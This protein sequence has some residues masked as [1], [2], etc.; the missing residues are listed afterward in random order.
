MADRVEE[1]TNCDRWCF[2]V[3]RLPAMLAH[4]GHVSVKPR[5]CLLRSLRGYPLEP[6]VVHKPRCRTQRLEPQV[7]PLGFR[8]HDVQRCP[9][10]WIARFK[11]RQDAARRIARDPSIAMA[12]SAMGKSSI[13]RGFA[14]PRASCAKRAATSTRL[15]TAPSLRSR[16]Q[17]ATLAMPVVDN[18]SRTAICSTS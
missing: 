18:V 15:A 9:P 14:I 11:W 17:P 12:Q 1:G 16:I 8:S 10:I 4:T 6:G 2:V 13:T 7:E 3:I 5:P